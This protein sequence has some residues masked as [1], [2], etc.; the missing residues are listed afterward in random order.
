MS[1]DGAPTVYSIPP[2]M[3]F[4]DA[5]A[6]GIDARYGRDPGALACLTVLLPT[7]R[8]VRSLRDAFLRLGG[9][10]PIL[11]P[12]LLPLGDLDEDEL[13]IAGWEDAAGGEAA[14]DIPPAI[15]GLRRQLLLARMIR[16]KEPE[17]VTEEQCARLAAELARLLDQVQTER[18]DFA[19]LEALVDETYAEHWKITLEFLRIITDEWP[20]ILA[21][22]GCIDP[23]ERRN[24]VLEAQ[25]ALWQRNP[26][27]DPVIAAGSTGTIPATADLLAAVARLPAGC[28]VLPGLDTGADAATW[29]ALGQ[30]H[31]QYGMARLLAHLGLDP[32]EVETWSAPGVAPRSFITRCGLPRPRRTGTTSTRPTPIRSTAW[33]GSMPPIPARRP[34]S[35]R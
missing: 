28:V 23:A 14:A 34:R 16:A 12:R 29:T 24:R 5:L 2:G 21:E 26:P 31:P 1:G 22:E 3:P 6:A 25:T 8:A 13:A 11:L 27:A 19:G 9:G 18:L 33:C 17:D 7:R 30:T 15:A 32:R 35:S 20:K 10:T 4:V